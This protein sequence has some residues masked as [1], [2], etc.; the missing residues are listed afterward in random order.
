MFRH[1]QQLRRWAAY[2][3]LA[4]LFGLT[5]GVANACLT[6][7][8]AELGLQR[9]G[10]L[11]ASKAK[12]DR[13]MPT[14]AQHHEGHQAQ[15]RA[16]LDH[17]ASPGQP[18]CLDFCD[19]AKISIPTLKSV[20]DQVDS[21]A[22]PPP[23]IAMVAPIPAAVPVQLWVPRRDGVLAPPIRIAFLRLAL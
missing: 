19:K 9:S 21:P 23:A 2:V 22:L 17:K 6:A 5:A 20:L 12:A 11:A 18:D 7:S 4:W 8:L 16:A 10:H 13:T 1:R 3:L 14:C 15:L